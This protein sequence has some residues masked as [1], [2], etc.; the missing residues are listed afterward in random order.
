MRAARWN[1]FVGPAMLAAVALCAVVGPWLVDFD[2]VA[3][4]TRQRLLPPLSTLP[5]GS[6]AYLGT[7]QLGRDI[8]TQILVGARV[9]LGIA[10]A[11]ALVATLVGAVVGVAAGWAGGRTSEALVRVIDVQLS[12]PSILIAVFL[13]AFIPPS[14]TTVIVVLAVTRWAAIARLARAITLKAKS[15][16]YVESALVSG[17][18]IGRII[19]SCILPN[20]AAPLLVLVT[21]DLS[22]IILAE[23]SLS[24]V[25]L[26][27]PPNVPSWGRVIANGRNHLDNAWWISTIPGLA[28]SLVVIS[29]GL[30]GETLR[31]H[32]VRDGWTML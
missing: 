22:L 25:G 26:G 21:A 12:F 14:I 23:A 15:Q 1:G 8:L 4:S 16:S 27:S 18:P 6:I 28:I 5:N 19:V 29:I 13:A 30:T 3:V 32:L 11:A 20:L 7:D 17:L 2:P 31:R 9:S 10:L 24:F